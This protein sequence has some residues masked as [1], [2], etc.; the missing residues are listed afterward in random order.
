MC[1]FHLKPKGFDVYDFIINKT[2]L[3]HYNDDEQQHLPKA[4]SH[5]NTG[6]SNRIN[7]KG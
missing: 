7:R 2:T 4:L 6:L 5:N 3:P 1:A